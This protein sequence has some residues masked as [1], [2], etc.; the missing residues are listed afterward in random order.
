M[1]PPP[2]PPPAKED[3]ISM[4][5]SGLPTTA[6]VTLVTAR[7]TR[8]FPRSSSPTR[9]TVVITG[10]DLTTTAIRSMMSSDSRLESR[11]MPPTVLKLPDS[12]LLSMPTPARL[13]PPVL[14]M[15]PVLPTPTTGERKLPDGK[16]LMLPGL[17]LPPVTRED[18][19]T[20]HTRLMLARNLLTPPSV[21]DPPSTVLL[22]VLALTLTDKDNSSL[23]VLV[24]VLLLLLPLMDM[25]LPLTELTPSRE[26]SDTVINNIFF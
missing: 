2:S 12:T 5:T 21:V 15:L 26:V 18:S 16:T 13:M 24:M 1:G 19:E 8:E 17:R 10:R 11:R 25:L 6:S 23:D 4:R 9:I 22:P 7:P 14:P 20:T 3:G